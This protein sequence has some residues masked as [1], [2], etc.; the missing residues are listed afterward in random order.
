MFNRFHL[1][2]VVSL[3]I[4]AGGLLTWYQHKQLGMPFT[5]DETQDV[6]TIDANVLYESRTRPAKISLYIPQ[7]DGEFMPLNERF[8]SDKYGTKVEREGENRQLTWSIRKPSG[9][10]SLY[11]HVT[12][13][14]RKT[15]G[16]DAVGP[17]YTEKN[18]FDTPIE[19]LAAQ[20][21]TDLIREQTADIQTFVTTTV[22]TLNDKSN[23]N[24]QLLLE[25]ANNLQDKAEIAVRLLSY[26]HIPAQ[27]I[28]MLP[29]DTGS[30]I[31]PVIWLRCYNEKEWLYFNFKN[32]DEGFPANHIQWWVG[33]H[34]VMATRGAKNP[35]LIFSVARNS[36]NTMQLAR[37]NGGP[38]DKSILNEYSLFSLPVK[39]QPVYQTML[40]VPVGVL[41]I[42]LLRSFIGLVTFGTFTPVLIALAFRETE[43]GWGIFLFTAITSL[44]LLVR[45]YLEQLRLLLVPRLGVILTV[46]V[47]CMGFIS[48]I[49]NKLGF[50][51]GLSIALF[52]MVILTMSIERMSIIWEERG[53]AE[54]IK[55]GIGSLGAASIAYLVMRQ[56]ILQHIMFAFPGVT[57]M[58]VAVM[59]MIGRY[60]GYRLTELFRFK[61]LTKA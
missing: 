36:V 24:A 45:F 20:S 2:I 21:L 52:P 14:K 27:I 55:T 32:G 11:Y 35:E 44:G 51:R 50:E 41:V 61:A 37:M 5:P 1:S 25:K 16:N 30:N 7:F 56:P 58:L 40:M 53:A 23:N 47:V 15:S 43:L 38:G 18:E 13:A 46:V 9:R 31:E 60:S 29:L 8:I 3:L 28:H 42:L 12:V 54:S 17:T 59:L 22:R 4:L 49:G 26:A 10:Q 33:K 39:M 57:L 19:Q 48:V 6:W 34:P